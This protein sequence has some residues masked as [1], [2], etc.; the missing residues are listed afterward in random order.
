MSAPSVA[1]SRSPSLTGNP[2]EVCEPTEAIHHLK[3]AIEHLVHLWEDHA[4]KVSEGDKARIVKEILAS[5]EG[6]WSKV[7]LKSKSP[8]L[9]FKD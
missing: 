5:V 2:L 9:P 6:M 3:S 8:C 7:T 1:E 4:S